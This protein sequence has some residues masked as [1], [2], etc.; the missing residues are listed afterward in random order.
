MNVETIINAVLTRG[1]C[2]IQCASEHSCQHHCVYPRHPESRTSHKYVLHTKSH[3]SI[4]CKAHLS[5]FQAHEAIT[6]PSSETCNPRVPDQMSSASRVRKQKSELATVFM[7]EIHLHSIRYV[8]D[9][10]PQHLKTSMG[11]GQNGRVV[12]NIFEKVRNPTYVLVTNDD[13]PRGKRHKSCER[14]HPSK[15]ALHSVLSDQG[16]ERAQ[17][18]GLLSRGTI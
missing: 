9:T 14:H 8:Q 1:F 12:N 16:L 7:R 4:C 18:G 5:G 13:S 6:S 3:V 2:C 11:V 17:N 15:Q 10:S